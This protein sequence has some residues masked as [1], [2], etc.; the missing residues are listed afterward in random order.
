MKSSFKKDVP[1]F[2]CCVGAY[3]VTI[4]FF[5]ND[6]WVCVAVTRHADN[7]GYTNTFSAGSMWGHWHPRLY[8][9]QAGV[10]ASRTFA[11]LSMA[12]CWFTNVR[13][14]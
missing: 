7:V 5:K 13:R 1:A 6:D 3:T 8:R 11:F 9:V 10:A 4:N 12:F 2:T 14:S